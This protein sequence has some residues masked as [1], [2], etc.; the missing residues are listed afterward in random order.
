M[1]HRYLLKDPVT[2]KLYTLECDKFL[3]WERGKEIEYE[4]MGGDKYIAIIEQY[5]GTPYN[6]SAQQMEREREERRAS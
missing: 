1:M 4:D 6:K 2:T 3:G 5:E